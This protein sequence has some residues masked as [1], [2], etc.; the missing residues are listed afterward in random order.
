MVPQNGWFLMENLLK[1]MIWG[2]HPYFWKQPN[3][4]ETSTRS[5]SQ[6]TSEWF[7]FQVQ[8]SQITRSPKNSSLKN[9]LQIPGSK[10][11]D[12]FFKLLGCFLCP[13]PIVSFRE[14]IMNSGSRTGKPGYSTSPVPSTTG[15][16]GG[17]PPAAWWIYGWWRWTTPSKWVICWIDF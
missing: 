12:H 10:C 11:Q 13:C 14:G 3:I 9:H 6:T 16:A 17:A 15:V 5:P 7:H 8:S 4:F 1:W 2:A